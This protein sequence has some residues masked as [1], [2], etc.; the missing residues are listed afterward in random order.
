MVSLLNNP[1]IYVIFSLELVSIC[2]VIYG[3]SA[4]RHTG[5][6]RRGANYGNHSNAN[7]AYGHNSQAYAYESTHHQR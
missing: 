5:L 2:K 4:A 7:T 6:I 1:S 3:G